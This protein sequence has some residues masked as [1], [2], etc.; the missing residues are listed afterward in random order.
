M[1]KNWVVTLGDMS[2]LFS[3]LTFSVFCGR[4]AKTSAHQKQKRRNIY[5]INKNNKKEDSSAAPKT[6][7]LG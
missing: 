5:V 6:M 1:M 7:K 3:F 4:P 2:V